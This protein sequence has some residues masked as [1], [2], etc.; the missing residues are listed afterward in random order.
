MISCRRVARRGDLV[1]GREQ[2][3]ARSS[4]GEGRWSIRLSPRFAPQ[5][6]SNLTKIFYDEV[7]PQMM[8]NPRLCRIG[9]GSAI[10]INPSWLDS[11]HESVGGRRHEGKAVLQNHPAVEGRRGESA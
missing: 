9:K 6:V 5:N 2:N 4:E 10:K 8:R 7:S 11:L 3:D 1:E